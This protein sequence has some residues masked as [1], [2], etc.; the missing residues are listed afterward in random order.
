LI[1]GSPLQLQV[2]KPN[3]RARLLEG[4]TKDI[5]PITLGSGAKISVPIPGDLRAFAGHAST[6]HAVS[7]E[8]QTESYLVIE[9]VP[10]P[11]SPTTALRAFINC[12][13]PAPG[14]SVDDPSYVGTIS[15]FGG[16]HAEMPGMGSSS[17]SVNITDVLR[18]AIDANYTPGSAIEVGLVPVDLSTPERVSKEEVIR[19]GRIQVIAVGSQL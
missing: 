2:K 18:R 11:T 8:E 4:Q 10:K 17:F 7:P 9:D 3:P 15:F 6:A 12:A 1:M 19:P 5:P 16:D 14:T 13:S